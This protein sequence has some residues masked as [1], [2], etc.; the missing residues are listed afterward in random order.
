MNLRHASNKGFTLVELI[1][2]V[3]ILAIVTAAIAG[4]MVTGT[5][6]YTN[7]NTEVT[8]QE[9]AQL[10]VNQMADIIID[11]AR[12]VSYVEN[13]DN[14]ILVIY[15]GEEKETV[16]PSGAVSTSIEKRYSNEKNYYF[17]YDSDLKEVSYIE[18]GVE[19]NQPSED[20]AAV[21]CLL[22]EDVTDFTAD[23]SMLESKRVVGLS[24]TVE[25]RNRKYTANSNITIRNKILYNVIDPEVIPP[26]VSFRIQMPKKVYVL[27]PN[28]TFTLPEPTVIGKNIKK[29]AGNPGFTW[30]SDSPEKVSV[31]NDGA[32]TVHDLKQGSVKLKVSGE[33]NADGK[34]YKS[35]YEIEVVIKRANKVNVSATGNKTTGEIDTGE[36]IVVTAN[37]SGDKLGSECDRCKAATTNDTKVT[38]WVYDN[39]IFDEVSST[40]DSI[41]LKAKAEL[42][43]DTDTTIKV[44]SYHSK[45]NGS[46]NSGAGYKG[47]KTGADGSDYVYGELTLRTVKDKSPYQYA[48]FLTY[49][50]TDAGNGYWNA[51]VNCV[52]A[53]RINESGNPD[54]ATDKVLL[55]DSVGA[56]TRIDPDTFGL[57]WT[58]EH[59]VWV[60]FF[61]KRS[62]YD[63]ATFQADYLANSSKGY[64]TGSNFT[65]IKSLNGVIEV[66]TISTSF[67]GV[68]YKASEC[69]LDTILANTSN[70]EYNRFNLV[71]INGMYDTS[72]NKYIGMTVYKKDGSDWKKL[73][74]NIDRSGG[75]LNLTL[76]QVHLEP[77][78]SGQYGGLSLEEIK[79]TTPRTKMNQS[80]DYMTA[81]GEYKI[82]P[83]IVYRSMQMGYSV[84]IAKGIFYR[85]YT[86]DF[87]TVREKECTESNLYFKVLEPA[88]SYNLHGLKLYVDGVMRSGEIYF[89]LPSDSG[90]SKYFDIEHGKTEYNVK[91]GFPYHYNEWYTV[92]F[93]FSKLKCTKTTESGVDKYYLN[94]YYD[95]KDKYWGN[96][97]K[98]IPTAT[99]YWDN[100]KAEWQFSSKGKYDDS[101]GPDL[102]AKVKGVKACVH[103]FDWTNTNVYENVELNI[104][105]PGDDTFYPE[106]KELTKGTNTSIQNKEL[107]WRIYHNK[108]YS[109]NGT[110]LFAKI[111]CEYS[112]TD[113]YYYI[114]IFG[115]NKTDK[116]STFSCGKYK[117]KAG[118]TKWTYIAP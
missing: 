69:Y 23:L 88:S 51:G 81:V 102:G 92:A 91:S 108:D 49:G 63:Q 66:P 105:V 71:T 74:S 2:G 78:I 72:S 41:T 110:H 104:P 80:G 58:K 34:K 83:A 95:A 52:V 113:D 11:A 62:G 15:N 43:L 46:N 27:E 98:D 29:T 47:G 96:T 82:V 57:D 85:N 75:G 18:F 117:A 89:P 5:K 87:T 77:G 32:V 19:Y 100:T 3:A 4:F 56:N 1:I 33:Y 64:Y 107:P 24:I 97:E 99:Y 38:D 9:E 60:E 54:H 39:G 6:N 73:S 101:D 50:W 111:T 116:S 14:R 70:A 40:D 112:N 65:A 53:I 30:T 25:R 22:A 36:T 37:V 26:G 109:E 115:Y 59:F 55:M 8:I 106:F 93:N 84:E 7:A 45:H 79:G 114:E 68:T 10:A 44:Y 42:P 16:S 90:F 94:L 12:S 48:G 17:K 21:E 35:A 76:E 13:G 28:D 31:T 20:S 103:L 118:D 61:E 67:N 86:P